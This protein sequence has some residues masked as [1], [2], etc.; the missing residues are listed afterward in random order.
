MQSLSVVINCRNAEGVIEA[1]LQSLSGL[2]D[3]IM[4]YDNGSTDRTMELVKKYPA[5]L[6][7][8]Q[9]EGFGPTKRKANRLAKYDWILS[10]DADEGI[11][12]TLKQSLLQLKLDDTLTVYDLAFKNFFGEKLLRFGEWG[13]D[14]HVRLF[15]RNTVNWN[16]APVHEELLLPANVRI[17]KLKGAVLHRTAESIKAYE[18]KLMGYA[19]L[20]AEKYY[21]HGKKTGT[22]RKYVSAAFNFLK[23]Y[24][25]RLGFLDGAA[26]YQCAAMMA[27]YTFSKYKLLEEMNRQK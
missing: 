22:A 11:D 10:L 23:N 26:G 19:V 27:R 14:H 7:Q 2:T 21:Q 9:W 8:G 5:R 1:T 12:E 4:V 20:N 13:G 16:D 25:F 18:K 15:N 17:E 3:D 6:E 24:I